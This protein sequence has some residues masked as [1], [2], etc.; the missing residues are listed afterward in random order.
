MDISRSQFSKETGTTF[1][2]NSHFIIS[3]PAPKP[4]ENKI[5]PSVSGEGGDVQSDGDNDL[6][7]DA[8]W[9]RRFNQELNDLCRDLN[10]SKN[11]SK[12]LASRLT[13]KNL[14]KSGNNITF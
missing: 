3:E 2:R 11:S 8:D 13:E 10:F 12:L 7:A 4:S 14:N 1:R 9:P 5:E 6:E